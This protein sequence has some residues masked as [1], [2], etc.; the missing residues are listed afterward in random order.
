MSQTGLQD[1]VCVGV[2]VIAA[3]KIGDNFGLRFD[4]IVS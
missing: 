1:E 3:R 2:T 4:L